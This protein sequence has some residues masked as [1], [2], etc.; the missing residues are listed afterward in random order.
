MRAPPRTVCGA[1]VV[2]CAAPP[3]PQLRAAKFGRNRGSGRTLHDGARPGPTRLGQRHRGRPE[4]GGWRVAA[5]SPDGAPPIPRSRER[6]RRTG[7]PTIEFPS[8]SYPIY[9]HPASKGWVSGSQSSEVQRHASQ[10]AG[11]VDV[12]GLVANPTQPDRGCRVDAQEHFSCTVGP[13]VCRVR[14]RI[15]VAWT[16]ERDRVATPSRW[17]ASSR[18]YACHSTSKSWS[19]PLAQRS[20]PPP[21]GTNRGV[22]RVSLVA[23]SG[24]EADHAC[25]ISTTRPTRRAL[26]AASTRRVPTQLPGPQ[27]LPGSGPRLQRVSRSRPSA[28]RP[29]ESGPQ[30][31]APRDSTSATSNSRAAS[32]WRRRTSICANRRSASPSDSD[33]HSVAAA[34]TASVNPAITA[35][36]GTGPPAADEGSK[37][38]VLTPT[39]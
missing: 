30:S 6:G 9:T 15:V 18:T 28:A 23:R 26:G 10:S 35:S 16:R 24:S 8:R 13:C 27:E 7:R 3:R 39:T 5:W 17:K 37:V 31:I 33:H 12:H 34:P 25:R 36:T 4:Q 21:L 29:P 22:K 14:E 20:S 1:V 11:Q 32:S 38:A 19:E 2:G